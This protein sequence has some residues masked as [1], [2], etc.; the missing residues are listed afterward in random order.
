[1]AGSAL[2]ISCAGLLRPIVFIGSNG[3]R[4]LK[5][6]QVRLKAGEMDAIRHGVLP[7]G[8]SKMMRIDIYLDIHPGES[9]GSIVSLLASTFL[10]RKA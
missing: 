9:S 4:N 3:T 8:R 6:S 2:C 10:S 7:T 1:M 5:G